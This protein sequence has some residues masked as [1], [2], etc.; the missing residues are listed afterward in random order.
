MT[1]WKPTKVIDLEM[2]QPL[3]DVVGL[4]G[5]ERILVLVRLHGAPIGYVRMPITGG[6]CAADSIMKAILEKHP[7]G[8]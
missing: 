1:T 8:I 5:Y 7:S 3:R 6:R 4:D 2:S